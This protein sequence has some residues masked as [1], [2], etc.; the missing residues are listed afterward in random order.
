MRPILR[1][2][3]AVSVLA[4]LMTVLP[5]SAGD[6]R[7]EGDSIILSVRDAQG[8]VR[9]VAK[10]RI[11]VSDQGSIGLSILDPAGG[12]PLEFRASNFS[13]IRRNEEQ[14]EVVLGTIG[15]A[16]NANFAIV[17]RDGTVGARLEVRDGG[18]TAGIELDYR[19]KGSPAITTSGAQPITF[20]PNNTVRMVLYPSAGGNDSVMS[21]WIAGGLRTVELCPD[22]SAGPGKRAL[23]MPN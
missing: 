5:A 13:T 8:V 6:T 16:A 21:L 2:R 14:I 17:P 9:E 1:I 23:C 15:T 19:V 10:F 18:D 7:L 11:L 3:A 12:L 4:I 20:K 22:D